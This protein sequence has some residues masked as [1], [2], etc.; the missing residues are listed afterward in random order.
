MNESYIGN[1]RNKPILEVI[2]Q[3]G[4]WSVTN[5]NWSG[6]SWILEKVLA[7]MAVDL[8]TDVFLA[9]QVRNNPFNTSEPLLAVSCAQK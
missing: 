9:F 1:A 2:E 5:E 4:S 8:D 3:Y 7:R 6:D